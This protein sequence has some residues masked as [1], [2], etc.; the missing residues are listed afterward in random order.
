[1]LAHLIVEVDA[2]IVLR[3]Q[4]QSSQRLGVQVFYLFGVVGLAWSFWWEALLRS[5]GPEGAEVVELLVTSNTDIQHTYIHFLRCS[6]SK[7][8]F[9][10]CGAVHACWTV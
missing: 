10:L 5:I 2:P 7:K 6:R 3:Y 9:H 4:R 1:M 8:S